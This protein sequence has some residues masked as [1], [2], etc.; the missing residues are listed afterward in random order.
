MESGDSLHPGTSDYVLD[1][2]DESDVLR[3]RSSWV[4]EMHAMMEEMT[5]SASRRWQDGSTLSTATDVENTSR[6]I[7]R[8]DK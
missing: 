8:C 6:D 5:V 3:K 7:E 2:S 4:R 1:G